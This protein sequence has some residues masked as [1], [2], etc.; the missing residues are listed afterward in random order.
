[1]GKLV[2]KLAYW[3]LGC[4][5]Q[6]SP[7][8]VITNYKN[9]N[10][11]ICR[12]RVSRLKLLPQQRTL[13]AEAIKPL[14]TWNPPAEMVLNLKFFGIKLI[15]PLPVSSPQQK[16]V[17]FSLKIPQLNTEPATIDLKSP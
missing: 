14:Q 7:G 17:L 9:Q 12:N 8:E 2:G 5:G 4:R 16:S 3:L 13:E 15:T 10:P 1:M 6:N 11:N